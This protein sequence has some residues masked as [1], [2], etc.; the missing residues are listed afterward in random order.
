MTGERL[1]RLFLR[2]RLRYWPRSRRLLAYRVEVKALGDVW[3][4]CDFK[5]RVLLIDCLA[6]PDDRSIRATLLHEMAH[7]AVGRPGHGAPFWTQLETLLA[8]RA[9]M[10]VGFPELGEQ[11]RHLYVIPAR[12]KRCRRLLAPAYRRYQREIE[13][14][15]A[16]L[17]VERLD[18]ETECH[19]AAA[20]EGLTW[21]H[22]WTYQARTWGFVDLDGR[23]LPWARQHHAAA[24]RG[25]VRGRRLFLREEKLAHSSRTIGA[26]ERASGLC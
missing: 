25:Y 1:N 4:R 18:L 10:T 20:V 16:S 23:L 8:Q 26:G 24:R 7:A 5:E 6:H 12:F 11:G 9:P 13:R 17:P 15:A 19:D 21:R 14:R 2:Y 22:I 3:G